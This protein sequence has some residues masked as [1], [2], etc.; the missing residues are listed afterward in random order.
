MPPD[1]T[2]PIIARVLAEIDALGRAGRAQDMERLCRRLLA[3]YPQCADGWNRLAIHLSG[4]GSELQAVVCL[5]R[6]IAAAPR[7]PSYRANLG[8][9]LR[10]A[11]LADQALAHCRRAIELDPE[12]VVAN[13]NLGCALMDAGDAA[14][15]QAHFARVTARE[16][17]NAQGWFGL[18]RAQF[19]LGQ[20]A[21]S[22]Q[23]LARAVTLAPGDAAARVTLA[24]ARLWQDDFAE[25]LA[26]ARG[27]AGLVPGHPEATAAMADVYM[28][29]GDFV[30]AEQV[31]REAL[32][33]LPGVIPFTYRLALC[34]LAQGD[35][36][37][38]FALYE[39]RVLLEANNRIQVPIL[40]MP[41]WEGQDLRGKRLLVLTEQGFGDHIQFC[42]FASRL[43]D[44]G[45]TVEFAVSPELRAVTH[46]LPGVTRVYT[47]ADQGRFSGCDYWTLVGS[48]P[49][50]LGVDATQVAASAPYLVADPQR[51]AHWRARLAELPGRLRIGLVWGGR[52]THENDHRRSLPFAALTP[53]AQVGAPGEIAWISL[54]QGPRAAEASA[55]PLRL[56]LLGES[57]ESFADV[58]ALMAELDL[59]ISVD[60]A[61]VHL[62]GALGVPVWVLLPRVADWRW[63]LGEGDTP[64]YASMRLFRQGARGEWA[65]VARAVARALDQWR[66]GAART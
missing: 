23:A 36:R 21:H 52:P 8:E 17:G 6:A 35:Y 57:F 11:G 53:L 7:E 44:A 12:H 63:A 4:R 42:R 58:A 50:R 20:I 60:S 56:A 19:A 10:R 26:Q 2:A 27:A 65:G 32:R 13:L 31:L 43:A 33:A 66:G 46:T 18:G 59:V 40:P 37:E 5:E 28:Q 25:A 45:A 14:A 62:A 49:Y 41:L 64:W 48:L 39:S 3:E 34:R 38:G 55:G 29:W 9:I 15:A 51:R 54:Q 47:M 22:A 1:A 30:A 24:R 61:P 16:P